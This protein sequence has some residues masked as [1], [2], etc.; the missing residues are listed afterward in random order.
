MD[1]KLN[2]VETFARIK[3]IGVGGGGCNAV[4]RMIEEGIQGVEF[5]AIN[6]DGQAL[7][8]SEAPMRVRLGD[9]LTRGLGAGGDPEIGRKA[10]EES[11]DDLYNVLKGADMVFVTAGLGGGTGT[12]AAP[13][14]AQIAR[15]VGALTLGVV[16]RPFAFEGRR[17][18]TQAENGIQRLKEK[19]DMLI[20]GGGI[21]NTFLAA[22]GAQVGKSLQEADMHDTARKL[23]ARAKERGAAIP[24]PTDV[25]VAKEFA[26]T[27]HADVRPVAEVAAD[28][29]IL[30]IGPDTAEHLAGLLVKA[31]TILWNGPVGVFEFDQFG[32]GTKAIAEGIASSKA[33]S[34]A[35]GGDTLAAIEKYGVGDRISY[36][37]TGGGAF[38]EFVEGKVLPAVAMLTERAGG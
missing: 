34:L 11:S 21:A 17:R 23:L 10:A 14:V 9:K 7:L 12:G 20:V 33:Y 22:T 30:D 15:E 18:S 1:V 37:S 24:L 25:V 19:V 36:I 4:N 6:T 31:G 38:L 29:M 32:E 35:G 26:A 3:V 5:I 2:Q 16:T 13:I 8:L 27:A 28:E